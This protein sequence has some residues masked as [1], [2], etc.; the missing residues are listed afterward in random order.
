MQWCHMSPCLGRRNDEGTVGRFLRHRWA[1]IAGQVV[2]LTALVLGVVAFTGSN[3][4][5]TLTVQP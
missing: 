4:S 3:K 5:V 1:K 2:V